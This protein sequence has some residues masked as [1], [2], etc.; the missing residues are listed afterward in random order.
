[1]YEIYTCGCLDMY[2]VTDLRLWRHTDA[3]R[4][5]HGVCGL[6]GAAGG[7]AARHGASE[8][9]L[10]G[11]ER[12]LPAGR[13]LVVAAADA[14]ESRHR[15][16]QQ[17]RGGGARR[18]GVTRVTRGRGH[19]HGMSRVR[20]SACLSRSV[21]ANVR[22]GRGIRVSFVDACVVAQTVRKRALEGVH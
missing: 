22:V 8:P 15:S 19:V 11:R 13:G 18:R 14:W 4:V 5:V 20:V 12:G 6:A 16:R 17:Q 10:G 2:I 1:M 9:R 21:C 3:G 7:D